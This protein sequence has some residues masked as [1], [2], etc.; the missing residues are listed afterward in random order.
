MRYLPLAG[1][2]CRF[3]AVCA[4]ALTAATAG[5]ASA[6]V[7]APLGLFGGRGAYVEYPPA[8]Y[9]GYNLDDR[10]P[11]YY[12]GSRYREYYSFGRG[13]GVA[14]FPG[15][16]PGPAYYWDWTSPWR[17]AFV[18]RPPPPGP[19]HE[20][21]DGLPP[22]NVVPPPDEPVVLFTVEVPAAAEVTIEGV[23]CK[24]TG[25]SRQFVSPP[26]VPG[27][28]YAYEIRA[29]WTEDGREVEQT[30][31]LVVTAGERLV[32]SFGPPAEGP[33][34]APGRLLVDTEQ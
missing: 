29:R 20:V 12:G 10:H 3:P 13:Y 16:V 23:K 5:E 11:G 8:S 27:K 25:T 22:V 31:N 24:Q 32:V 21:A 14:N 18:L 1:L 33:L 9:F 7:A 30:R 15:P 17:R 26:L 28:Q 2:G 34:P 4:L 6:Q 19:V